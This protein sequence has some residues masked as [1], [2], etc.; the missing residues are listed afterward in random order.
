MCIALWITWFCSIKDIK[1]TEC[2]HSGARRSHSC[3]DP[4]LK[5][6]SK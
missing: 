2:E 4:F 6:S 3:G 1:G 5:A